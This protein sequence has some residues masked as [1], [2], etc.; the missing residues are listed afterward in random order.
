MS[1]L[2]FKGGKLE[3]IAGLEVVSALLF[4]LPSTRSFG[5]LL[6]SAYMGGAI[7]THVQH[8][9]LH[10]AAPASAVLCLIW[11]GAWLRHPEILWSLD[12]RADDSA[13]L[14]VENDVKMA[15]GISRET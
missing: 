3:L 4:L 2:G 11:L 13:G 8:D 10:L 5:L 7:A 15:V 12:R 14:P 1:R 9:Q 6:V